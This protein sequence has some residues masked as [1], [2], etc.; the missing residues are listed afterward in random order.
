[1]LTT[2]SPNDKSFVRWTFFTAKF[3][4]GKMSVQRI[5]LRR[6][7]RLW[8]NN[9]KCSL[10]T[11]SEQMWGWTQAESEE[12]MRI[13]CM[14]YFI[15]MILPMFS[16]MLSMIVKAKVI[17]VNRCFKFLIKDLQLLIIQHSLIEL[18]SQVETI[19]V[20]S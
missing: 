14:F 7:F 10:R 3:S 12:T 2:R 11:M 13:S 17:Q 16:S 18:T 6:N 15:F 20:I 4:Y 5:F 9:V 19:C 8:V 1:M